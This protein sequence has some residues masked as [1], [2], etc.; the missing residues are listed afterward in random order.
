MTHLCVTRPQ[1]VNSGASYQCSV[2]DIE[3]NPKIMH[4]HFS[5]LYSVVVL[6]RWIYPYP[7]GLLHCGKNI[8]LR[9]IQCQWSK[10]EKQRNGACKSHQ[11]F[12][13][14]S[15]HGSAFRISGPL[16]GES[17]GDRGVPF[18]KSPR[19]G[20]LVFPLISAWTNCLTNIRVT[21]KLRNQYKIM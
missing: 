17:T 14:K 6:C 2:F 4:G 8:A 1:W 12:I 13:T 11:N 20:D 15:W 18:T 19:W 5:L 16:W 10:P 7:S 9:L 21:G 3:Y